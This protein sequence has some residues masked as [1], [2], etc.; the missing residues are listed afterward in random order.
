MALESATYIDQLREDAPNGLDPKSQGDDHIRL[1]KGAIKRTF[2]KVT[3]EVTAT[4]QQ[5][6]ALTLPGNLSPPGIVAIWP[7]AAD[8]VPAGWA[9]C[10]GVAKMNDGRTVPDYRGNFPMGSN[11]NYPAGSRGGDFTHTHTGTIGETVLTI[12]QIPSHSHKLRS[13]RANGANQ[14]ARPGEATD[15]D[16][17]SL[18]DTESVGGGKG[19]THTA[20]V[21]RASNLPPFV[22][23]LFII[24]L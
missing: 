12:D 17:S 13:W 10:D 15:I 18:G 3:G 20:T 19:H 6:N 22:A 16:S 9:V 24:K 14:V 8:L 2:P 11:A 1:V 7:F 21:D 4:H 23:I 5:I